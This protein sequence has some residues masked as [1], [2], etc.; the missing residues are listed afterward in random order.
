VKWFY[1]PWPEM[2][3]GGFAFATGQLIGGWPQ[4]F[5]WALPLLPLAT[6]PHNLAAPLLFGAAAG[7]VVT[8]AGCLEFRR[9]EVN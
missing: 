4:Y 8:A 1:S 3:S 7:I 9:R 2:E 6:R 5:P